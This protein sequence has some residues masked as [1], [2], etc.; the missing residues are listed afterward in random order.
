M[1]YIISLYLSLLN[2][3]WHEKDFHYFCLLATTK[4]I[5]LTDGM[6]ILMCRSWLVFKPSQTS[7]HRKS[8]RYVKPLRYILGIFVPERTQVMNF[9]LVQFCLDLE[10]R[11]FGY[12]TTLYICDHLPCTSILV[13][14]GGRLYHIHYEL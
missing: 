7:I 8:K 3:V 5:C 2:H 12:S 9:V 14:V 6:S 4:I 1:S 11:V 13:D 10:Q